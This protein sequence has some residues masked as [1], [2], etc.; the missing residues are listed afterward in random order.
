VTYLDANRWEQLI[1]S[2][3][4]NLRVFDMNYL[5]SIHGDKLP[6]DVLTENFNY[7]FWNERKTLFIYRQEHSC[8]NIRIKIFYSID[9][10]KYINKV[11]FYSIN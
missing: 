7:S 6:C 5:G 8:G 1:L 3:M 9:S 10:S 4:R 11:C 2:H